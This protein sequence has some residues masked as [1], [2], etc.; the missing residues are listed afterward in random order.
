[1]DRVGRTGAAV[2]RATFEPTCNVAGVGG[3]Y[4]EQGTKTVIP[5]VASAKIDFRLV[6]DQDPED[7]VLNLCPCTL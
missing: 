3:G 5:A 6:P 4:Q 2:P 7:E 1:M